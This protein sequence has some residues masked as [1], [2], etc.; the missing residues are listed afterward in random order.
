M[1]DPVTI[2]LGVLT[3]L[4]IAKGK[5]SAES[6]STS[7]ETI[8]LNAQAL[9]VP[10][11][12]LNDVYQGLKRVKNLYG[13]EYAKKIEQVFRLETGHFTSSQFK[14][15]YTGGMVAQK[16]SFPYGWSSLE[17]FAKEKGILPS[18]FSTYTIYVQR[19]GNFFM[20]VKFPNIEDSILFTAW[21][22]KTIRNGRVGHWNSLDEST[23]SNY[24]NSLIGII[25]RI[26]NLF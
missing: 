18:Q 17:K 25:P 1:A 11:Q 15:G 26:S 13:K 19:D 7:S 16:N 22:I 12:Y 8:N 24:E 4:G 2:T 21:F 6:S 10:S 14:N 5:N 3:L 20:Y 23:A 9:K